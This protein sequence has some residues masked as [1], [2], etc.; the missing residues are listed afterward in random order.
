MDFTVSKEST[1]TLGDKGLVVDGR[2]PMKGIQGIF[3]FLIS[4]GIMSKKEYQYIERK[5]K[6]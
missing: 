1:V 4:R 3:D 5:M 2:D 6:A